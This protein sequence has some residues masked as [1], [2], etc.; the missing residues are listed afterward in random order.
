MA[1]TTSNEGLVKA[2]S[3][4]PDSV[5]SIQDDISM[6]KGG[7]T[8]T[9]WHES[10]TD[11]FTTQRT[12]YWSPTPSPRE[13]CRAG[14][15]KELEEVDEEDSEIDL[16]P[17]GKLA[18]VSD[19]TFLRWPSAPS[20]TTKQ[21]KSRRIRMVFQTPIGSGV[22]RLM[23]L[24]RQMFPQLLRRQTEGEPSQQFWLN[25][26]TPLVMV[27]EKADDLDNSGRGDNFHPDLITT[28]GQCE[29]P[30]LSFTEECLLYPVQSST[31]AIVQ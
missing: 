9:Q 26:V 20:Y 25:A 3:L 27:I 13:A 14:E 29:L 6:L 19:A 23:Q 24:W 15:D 12:W 28:H 16:E 7:A 22:Q 21:G 4:L 31:E 18:A 30:Q 1:E 11:Q 17:S 10:T 5:K 2:L 8:Y